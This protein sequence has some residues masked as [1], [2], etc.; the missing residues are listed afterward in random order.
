MMK[1]KEGEE[2]VMKKNS[3]RAKIVLMETGDYKSSEVKS[4]VFETYQEAKDWITVNL[5]F[6]DRTKR[7]QIH[8]KEYDNVGLIQ[9]DLIEYFYEW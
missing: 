5:Q 3:Y 7:V 2:K 1:T 8:S 6:F 9:K 4:P